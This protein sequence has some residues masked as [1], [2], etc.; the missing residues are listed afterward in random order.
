V[1]VCYHAHARFWDEAGNRITVP[2]PTD[3]NTP[4][5]PWWYDWIAEHAGAL[6]RAGFTAI[7]YPPVCKTASGRGPGADGYGVFDQY[8]LGSKRQCGSIETRF[9]A[10][11]QLKRSIAVAHACGLDVYVDVVMH[12]L[13]GGTQEGFYDYLAAD[14]HSKNGRFPKRPG[15]FRGPPPRR[16]QDPV[17]VPRDDFPFGDEFV[18]ANCEPPGYTT[19]GMV[20]FGEWLTR[21]LDIQGYRVDDTKGTSVGFVKKWM[22][23]GD[24]A[25]RFCVSEYFDGNPDGLHWWVHDSGMGGRSAVFDF[26]LH[27][28][29][30]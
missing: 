22:T 11:D 29:L 1:G 24:M 17:P 18:Y 15:C 19:N 13:S 20:A 12:Q 5:A 3:P 10:R 14:G 23:S 26:T 25:H 9:G 16:P 2:A 6:K 30:Q 28:A 7:L 21:C 8:D 27:W 4:D